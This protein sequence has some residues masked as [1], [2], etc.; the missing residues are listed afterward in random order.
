MK[1]DFN[2]QLAQYF[3]IDIF[4]DIERGRILL[5]PF[6]EL[7]LLERLKQFQA[8]HLGLPLPRSV[9]IRTTNGD[10]IISHPLGSA[11][12]H[13]GI[14]YQDIADEHIRYSLA[15]GEY[16]I[17]SGM[18]YEQSE[19]MTYESLSIDP[20]NIL[21]EKSKKISIIGKQK[22]QWQEETENAFDTLSTIWKNTTID[23]VAFKHEFTDNMPSILERAPWL[24]S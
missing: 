10:R 8:L 7:S 12:M 15:D 6:K 11:I 18:T 19:K 21:S 1:Q 3:I 22:H 24:F 17:S 23:G 2:F 16:H 5:A 13:E 20:F 9:I 4:R 14:F